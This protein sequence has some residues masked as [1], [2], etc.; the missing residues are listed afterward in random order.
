MD[1]RAP[2][3]GFVCESVYVPK[4][5]N[6]PLIGSFQYAFLSHSKLKNKEGSSQVAIKSLKMT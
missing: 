3:L 4:A 5:A 6:R 1:L 2:R